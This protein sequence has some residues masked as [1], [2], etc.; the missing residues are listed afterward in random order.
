MT[1]HRLFNWALAVFCVLSVAVLLGAGG[2]WLDDYDRIKSMQ[3]RGMR[4]DLHAAQYCRELHG[5]SG[6][7]WAESGELVCIPR[8]GKRKTESNFKE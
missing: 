8:H 4:R 6:Y 5:Q 1:P 7:Q 2:A 3:S